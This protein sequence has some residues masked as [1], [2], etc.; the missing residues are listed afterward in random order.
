MSS[1]SPVDFEVIANLRALSPDDGDVF[2]KEILNI[3][4]DDTPLRIAELHSS[5]V[6]GNSVNFVRAAHSI[7]GSSSNVGASELRALAEHLEHHARNKGL[8]ETEPQ[9]IAEIEAAFARVK[10]EL[11]KLIAS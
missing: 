1:P 8:A 9:Q 11:E 3:F 2:L 5:L 6:S 7:K 4:I 10:T